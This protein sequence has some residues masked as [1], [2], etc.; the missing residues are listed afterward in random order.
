MPTTPVL[1]T[2]PTGNQL[3]IIQ[4]GAWQWIVKALTAIFQLEQQI[5]AQPDTLPAAIG[6]LQ[7]EVHT[8]TAEVES[9]VATFSRP[10]RGSI[11]IN[12]KEPTHMPIP[13]SD[14]QTFTYSIVYDDLAGREVPEN[15]PTEWTVVDLTGAPST[16]ATLTPDPTSDEKGTGVLTASSGA[17]KL[18]ASM[19]TLNFESDEL[20]VVPGAP[21]TGVITVTAV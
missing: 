3:F 5:A 11:R 9:L 10:V 4:S 15:A 21:A 20:D 8:L 7:H 16:L 1:P 6:V 18:R 17:F 12:G 13:I 14:S 2:P 19:G